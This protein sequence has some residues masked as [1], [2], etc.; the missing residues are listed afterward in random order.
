MLLIIVYL[1][2]LTL[3]KRYKG[4]RIVN[5]NR[6]MLSLHEFIFIMRLCKRHLVE[7]V[8]LI[9]VLLDVLIRY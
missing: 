1:A 9:D 5:H 8:I 2:P 4:I 7:A 6:L 3:T